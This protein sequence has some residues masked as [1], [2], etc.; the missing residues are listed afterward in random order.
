MTHVPDRDWFA[1][2]AAARRQDWPD[3]ARRAEELGWP[4]V[5]HHARRAAFNVDSIGMLIYALL[6]DR[7]DEPHPFADPPA[8][9]AASSERQHADGS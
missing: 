8:T 9:V 6:L 2:R 3:V 5:A 7:P 4:L 1:I